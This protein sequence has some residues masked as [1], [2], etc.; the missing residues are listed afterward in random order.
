MAWH[1]QPWAHHTQTA[2]HPL[3]SLDPK[4]PTRFASVALAAHGR[5]DTP[6]AIVALPAGWERWRVCLSHFRR[7]R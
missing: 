3:L 1:S 2:L 6:P 7:S 4:T 5:S